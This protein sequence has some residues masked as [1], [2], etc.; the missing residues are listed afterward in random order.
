MPDAD[1]ATQTATSNNNSQQFEPSDSTPALNTTA[2]EVDD[3]Q[4]KYEALE[5]RVEKLMSVVNAIQDQNEKI[6]KML[7]DRS[8]SD[9]T[10][11]TQVYP[12]YPPSN[13]TYPYPPPLDMRGGPPYSQYPDPTHP[14][15]YHSMPFR[16]QPCNERPQG[17]ITAPGT[18][19]LPGNLY[20]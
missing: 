7:D 19:A 4:K 18:C 14:S 5:N 15:Y 8:Q 13:R 1:A 12:C 3:M 11:T 2:N 17:P 20:R 10:R 9:R 6:L 16:P